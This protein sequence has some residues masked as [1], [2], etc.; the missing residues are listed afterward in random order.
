MDRKWKVLL[1]VGTGVIL[2]KLV[3]ADSKPLLPTV[4]SVDL[5]R[6]VGKW[7][8]IARYPNWFEKEDIGDVTAEYTPLG[9][10]RGLVRGRGGFVGPI[11]QARFNNEFQTRG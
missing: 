6:Y 2:T 4:S 11:Y 5:T 3:L 1:A 9:Q 8:E 10:L 7:Y